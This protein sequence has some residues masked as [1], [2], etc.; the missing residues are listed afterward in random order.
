MQTLSPSK[1]ST[2]YLAFSMWILPL[3]VR[4]CRQAAVKW[5][6]HP[7]THL[8]EIIPYDGREAVACNPRDNYVEAALVAEAV[9]PWNVCPPVVVRAVKLHFVSAQV[10]EYRQHITL[11][12]STSVIRALPLPS[13]VERLV[14]G[15]WNC[16]NGEESEQVT[17]FSDPVL[18]VSSNANATLRS[19]SWTL[20]RP[21]EHSDQW[22]AVSWNGVIG[23]H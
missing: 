6:V 1:K 4:E 15:M 23:G 8:V 17:S 3:S 10:R 19:C 12:A 7:P 14:R 13:Q 22:R 21:H 16:R 9:D 18:Y 20:S 2:L 11:C 5:R